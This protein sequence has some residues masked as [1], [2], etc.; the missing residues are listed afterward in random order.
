MPGFAKFLAF[1]NVLA[2][3]GFLYLATIDYNARKPWAYQVFRAEL[4]MHGLPIDKHDPGPIR[5][6]IALWQDL[7]DETLTDMFVKAGGNPTTK[8]GKL[9]RTQR[10]EVFRIK[11]ALEAELKAL[12]DDDLRQQLLARFLP[13][14]LNLEER[15]SLAA[16][17]NDKDADLAK[18]SGVLV[19]EYFG[20]ILNDTDPGA[21]DDDRYLSDK[22]GKVAQT[23]RP[24]R[25]QRIAHLLY[26]LSADQQA[27]Q[28]VLA[29]IG[30][31]GYINEAQ[32]QSARLRE[33]SLR[34]RGAM[35]DER[36][37]FEI[38]YQRLVQRIL[39][40]T[41]E[42]ELKQIAYNDK[43]EL[44]KRT[45]ELKKLREQ[46]R[47]QLVKD[48]GEATSKLD[49]ALNAQ[50]W[51][52]EQIFETQKALGQM[53]ARADTLHRYIKRYEGVPGR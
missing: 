23:S 52:E 34:T 2:A 48:K 29:V 21:D 37:L 9:I 50:L 3:L 15:K 31:H 18:L 26:N 41:E 1:M 30:L 22:S 24:N 14:A 19:E 4:A 43:L 46:D 20:K 36:A 45:A 27:H 5:V 25:R 32:G 7:D 40:L 35:R 28:R 13:L 11:T 49:A 12:A 47:D 44:K 16:R 8:G 17:I 6:D 33:M 53:Q 39:V 10:D 38:E 51:W 42:I